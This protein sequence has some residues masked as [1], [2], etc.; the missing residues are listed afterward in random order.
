VLR[1]LVKPVYLSLREI[2]LKGFVHPGPRPV[3]PSSIKS[4]LVICDR[5]LGDVCLA[6]PTL[7][8]LRAAYRETGLGILLPEHLR[9]LV[10]WACHPNH[11]FDYGDEQRI[12]DTAWDLVIDLTTDYHLQSARLAAGTRCAV[13]IGFNFKGRGRYFNLPLEIPA[14]AQMRDVYAR[15]LG[16][17]GIAFEPSPLPSFI[18]AEPAAEWNRHA[19][20]VHPGAHH[21][22]QRWPAEYF[23]DLIGRIRGGGELCVVLGAPSEG[24]LVTDI[25]KRAGPGATAAITRNVLELAATIRASEVVICNNSG[26]LHLA[27]LLGVPTV[28]FM[29]PTLKHRWMPSGRYDVVLRRDDLPCIGCNRATCRIRTHACMKEIT[30]EQAYTAYF[31]LRALL[32][33]ESS[34]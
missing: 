17:L 14:E 2:L 24:E 25:V 11:F 27:G 5:R 28:S 19:I 13:R 6:I 8:C 1:T 30:P 20:A 4:I 23:A 9:P 21:P 33:L 12:A 7:Q 34:T 15:V 16:P 32:L 18:P 31:R 26:P 3:L 29:G 10:Q 22:T